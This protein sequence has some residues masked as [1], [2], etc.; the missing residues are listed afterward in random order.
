V[1]Y[2]RGWL[3][4]SRPQGRNADELP[5]PK[6]CSIA[7]SVESGQNAAAGLKGSIDDAVNNA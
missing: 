6:T 3:N 1:P 4:N 5:V 7:I 2:R